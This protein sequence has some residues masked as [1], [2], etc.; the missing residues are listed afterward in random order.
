MTEYGMGI[1]SRTLAN[2]ACTAMIDYLR[3][4]VSR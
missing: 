1:L 2:R 4:T 3:S